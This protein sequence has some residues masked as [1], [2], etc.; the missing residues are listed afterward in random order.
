MGAF[1]ICPGI[2][3]SLRKNLRFTMLLRGAS[4]VELA[5]FACLFFAFSGSK[6]KRLF[7]RVFLLAY[8]LRVSCLDLPRGCWGCWGCSARTRDAGVAG[9]AGDAGAWASS[10]V[11]FFRVSKF[12]FS[13][14]W[15]QKKRLNFRRLF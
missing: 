13:A 4:C 9:D 5:R 6:K 1:S 11:P 12:V 8:C 15:L 7:L 14:V 10:C 2:A 3:R